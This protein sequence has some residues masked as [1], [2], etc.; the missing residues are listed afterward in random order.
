MYFWK[1]NILAVC[2]FL[3]VRRS[4]CADAGVMVEL[5]RTNITILNV[6][7]LHDAG[8]KLHNIEHLAIIDAPQ[9]EHIAVEDLTKM[10]KLKSFYITQAPLLRRVPPLPSLPS[11]RTL[12]V[13]VLCIL[14]ITYFPEQMYL[15]RV[16]WGNNFPIVTCERFKPQ[17][18]RVFGI[19]CQ[20]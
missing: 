14:V 9:L 1:Q 11:L 8:H 10:P 7:A 3:L 15:F 20:C 16:T 13:C 17:N 19:Q 4:S 6:K 18:K 5:V 12:Y 2:I